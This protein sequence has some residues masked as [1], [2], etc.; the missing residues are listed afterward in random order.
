MSYALLYSSLN[1]KVLSWLIEELKNQIIDFDPYG[2]DKKVLALTYEDLKIF[3]KIEW[4]TENKENLYDKMTNVIE[5]KPEEVKAFLKVWTSKWLNKWRERVRVSQ[6]HPKL[7]KKQLL[8]LK[9]A[10]IVYKS[11]DSQK[12]KEMKKVVIEQLVEKGEICIPELVA[13]TIITEEIA[14]QL[15]KNKKSSI[16]YNYGLNSANFLQDLLKRVKTLAKSKIPVAYMKIK[17]DDD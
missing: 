11:L 8:N 17:I 7:S 2:L 10:K 6:K 12:R 15:E 1:P 5:N 13:K 14:T 4:K 9:N 16:K 3:L